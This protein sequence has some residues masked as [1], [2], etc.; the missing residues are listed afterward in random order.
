MNDFRIP[1]AMP[2]LGDEEIVAVTRA[3]VDRRLSMGAEVRAFEAEAATLANRE[4]GIG[5]ANGTVA[6]DLAMKL[7]G[8]NPGDEVIVSALS[9]IATTNC[10]FWQGA[11]PVFCDIDPAT[12]NIDPADIERRITPRTKAILVADYCGSPVDYDRIESICDDHGLL[13]AVDGAQSLGAYHRG[14]PTC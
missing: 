3:L 5:V 14:R 11:R 12:L 13:L 8:I 2:Y 10:I 1:W 7:S 4:H 6:L 9:Y